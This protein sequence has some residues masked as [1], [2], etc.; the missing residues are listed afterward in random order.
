MA[1]PGHL[2]RHPR[3]RALPWVHPALKAG[4][5]GCRHC[6][7]ARVHVNTTIWCRL[8]RASVHILPLRA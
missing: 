6:G 1:G 4:F 2:W 3:G 7:V 5:A 8:L